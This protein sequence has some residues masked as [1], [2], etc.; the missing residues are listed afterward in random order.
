MLYFN[1]QSVAYDNKKGN[2]VKSLMFNI[3]YFATFISK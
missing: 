2:I 3:F 1:N